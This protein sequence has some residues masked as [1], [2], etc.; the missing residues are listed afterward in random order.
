M[1]GL[2]LREGTYTMRLL[3]VEDNTM[4]ALLMQEAFSESAH[5]LIHV[6]TGEDALTYLQ[7]HTVDAVLLDL[8]LPGLSGADVLRELRDIP[9]TRSVLVIALLATSR[10]ADWWQGRGLRPDA[11]ASKPATPQDVSDACLARTDP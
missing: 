4:D 3:L 10:E 1:T 5:E 8:N 11:F 7:Q 9:A 2:T 6:T